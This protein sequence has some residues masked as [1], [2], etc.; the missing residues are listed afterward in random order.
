[1]SAINALTEQ[2]VYYNLPYNQGQNV[3]AYNGNVSAFEWKSKMAGEW[4]AEAYSYGYDDE[5]RLVSA[6]S[7]SFDDSGNV[8]IG[9]HDTHYTYDVMGNFTG[10]I[11]KGIN[12]DDEE[13]GYRDY[14]TLE[15]DG[16]QLVYVAND[17]FV[18]SSSDTQVSDCKYENVDEFKYDPN[19]NMTRNLNKGILKVTYNVLNLPECIY[20]TN[21]QYIYNVYDGDGNKLSS[22]RGTCRYNIV[23]PEGGTILGSLDTLRVKSDLLSRD[24]PDMTYYDGDFIYKTELGDLSKPSLGGVDTYVVGNKYSCILVLDRI[25]FDGG[26]IMP[27]KSKKQIYD[28]VRDY[29]GNIRFVETNN[30]IVETNNYYPFGGFYKDDKNVWSQR[31]KFGGKELLRMFDIYDF[32]GRWFDPTTCRFYSIDNFAEKYYR[33]SPYSFCKN[34]PIANIDPTGNFIIP[35]LLSDSNQR[36]IEKN[37]YKSLS[38]FVDA[39]VDFA[40][41]DFGKKIISDFL[42]IGYTQYGVSGNG[43]YADCGLYLFE[44]NRDDNAKSLNGKLYYEKA[45]ETMNVVLY[46]DCRNMSQAQIIE[47][48]VHELTLHGYDFENKLDD[49]KN[50]KNSK[51]F[52]TTEEEEHDDLLNK[53]HKFGGDEYVKTWQQLE[54]INP[55]YNGAFEQRLNDLKINQK[56]R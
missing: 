45:N 6:Y 36:N 54:D 41:T 39:M 18:D 14:V 27:R 53:T 33:L 49:Y 13:E 3:L 29:L 4:N 12:Y 43:K 51:C 1:M 26:F 50:G 28:Y 32:G 15:Y 35:C 17:G 52:N 22:E 46:V 37:Y 42:P 2:H 40:K 31:W 11:R 8:S 9:K 23:V 24:Y 56:N 25:N 34:N 47:T 20:M 44:D 30:R 55:S 5:N 38:K 7:M 16:N 48:I 10:I 19:G 21:N